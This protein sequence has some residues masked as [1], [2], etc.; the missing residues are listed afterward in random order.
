M[1]RLHFRT[2]EVIDPRF[3]N[4]PITVIRLMGWIRFRRE[5]GSFAE[6]VRAII[7]SGAFLSVLPQY[8]WRDLT[9]NISVA[10]V[11]FGGIN[12]HPECQIPAALGQVRGVLVDE[13]GAHS[14]E[15]TFP[16]FLAKTNQV[17]LILGF[18]GLLAEFKVCFDYKP[19]EAHIEERR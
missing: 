12:P 14:Q 10:D 7:D 8:V 15:I 13:K 17:P 9:V 3:G 2:R 4:V 16:A 19:D 1:I 5:D 6:M 11:S 18:A